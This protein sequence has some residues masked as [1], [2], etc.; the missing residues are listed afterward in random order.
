MIV[1]RLPF[2]FLLIYFVFFIVFV[3]FAFKQIKNQTKSCKTSNS[4]VI[5]FSCL[6]VSDLYV[7]FVYKNFLILLSLPRCSST[8][9]VAHVTQIE[10]HINTILYIKIS[11]PPK[12]NKKLRTY[13][14]NPSTRA[15]K[16][17]KV[18]Y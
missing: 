5:Y 3:E 10:E 8:V 1:L 11:S 6:L 9:T 14:P 2:F 15:R 7:C 16:R 13:L 4:N 17:V 12:I 18:D